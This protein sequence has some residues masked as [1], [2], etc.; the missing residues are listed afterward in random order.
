MEQPETFTER[1]NRLTSS[2]TDTKV[3]SILGVTEGAVRKIRRGDTQTIELHRAIRLCRELG[4]S[5][6]YLAGEREPHGQGDGSFSEIA[7]RFASGDAVRLAA[8]E[9]KFDEMQALVNDLRAIVERQ[10]GQLPPE[11]D[12]EGP[13]P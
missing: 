3:G 7:D 11:S 2:M 6:Y 4:V 1:F 13:Q 10:G 12:A 5:T 9:R 8:V